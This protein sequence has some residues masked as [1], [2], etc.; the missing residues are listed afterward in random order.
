MDNYT[1]EID[2]QGFEIGKNRDVI[3]TSSLFTL[4]RNLDGL[5]VKC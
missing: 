5:P 2:N 4:D 1:P 3:K